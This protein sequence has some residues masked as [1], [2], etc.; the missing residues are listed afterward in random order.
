MKTG[1]DYQQPENNLTDI[2]M[3]LGSFLVWAMDDGAMY[4]G[5]NAEDATTAFQRLL[6]WD[7]ER[8]TKF[9]EIIRGEG[10]E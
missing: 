8:M 10:I 5:V 7:D 4:G 6:G 3:D 9:A 2:L 1:S